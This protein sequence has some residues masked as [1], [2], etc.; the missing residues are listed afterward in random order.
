MVERF[1]AVSDEL[2]GLLR[3]LVGDQHTDPLNPAYAFSAASRQ[4]FLAQHLVL[5]TVVADAQMVETV[6]ETD[7]FGSDR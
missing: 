6:L 3:E 5:S 2:V 1:G 7:C 4:T